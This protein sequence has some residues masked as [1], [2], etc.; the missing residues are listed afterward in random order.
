MVFDALYSMIYAV[1]Y[2]PVQT[3][4]AVFF[5][6]YITML[7]MVVIIKLIVREKES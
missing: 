6:F 4:V 1:F 2:D 7:V 5:G 3:A